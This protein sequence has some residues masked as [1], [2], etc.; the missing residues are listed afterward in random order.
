MAISNILR[1]NC[2]QG[3]PDVIKEVRGRPV[4]DYRVLYE[5]QEGHMSLHSWIVASKKGKNQYLGGNFKFLS[6]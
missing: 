1:K 6:G 4:G 3:I 2:M 5:A